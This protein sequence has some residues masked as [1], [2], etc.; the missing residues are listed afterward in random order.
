ML[1]D[2]S[3]EQTSIDVIAT[4]GAVADNE[5]DPLAAVEVRDVVGGGQRGGGA[6][7]RCGN[8]HREN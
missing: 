5:V 3:R 2:E 8:K 7:Q 1:A 4:A 6:R